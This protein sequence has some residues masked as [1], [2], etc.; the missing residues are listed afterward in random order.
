MYFQRIMPFSRKGN[1]NGTVNILNEFL[2]EPA[3]PNT[4]L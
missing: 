3:L 2:Y 4:T 1:E